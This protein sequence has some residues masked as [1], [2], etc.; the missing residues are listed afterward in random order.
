M[1]FKLFSI[2]MVLF[3][4]LLTL[5]LAQAVTWSW[6]IVTSPLWIP[7]LIF[8]LFLVGLCTIVTV[9]Y[10]IDYLIKKGKSE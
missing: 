7:W 8:I 10:F 2:A 3:I 1:N 4:V 5:K 6:W 9:R